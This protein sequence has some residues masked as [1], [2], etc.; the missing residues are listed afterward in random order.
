[1]NKVFLASFAFLSSLMIME[2][3]STVKTSQ[4]S[5]NIV[6]PKTI[7]F[8]GKNLYGWYTFL[9]NRGRD[10]DPKKVFTV[11]DGLIHISGEEW[12]C[13]TTKE[14]YGN[15]K[16]VAEFKWGTRT[17]APRTEN[18]RDNGV[19]LNSTGVD[20]GAS[21]IWMHSI[22]SNIIEG[23]MGDLLVVGDGSDK[24]ALTSMVAPKKPG[25]W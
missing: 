17:Y 15:Y 1:M 13:I 6:L 16:L 11:H 25:K 9:K 19:L 14:E 12:G 20:G 2:G 22:E 23:G 24:F 7:L 21:G 10:N 18:A 4:D 3:C 8:N 5:G